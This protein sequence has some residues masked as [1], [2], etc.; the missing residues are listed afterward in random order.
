MPEDFRESAI[1]IYFETYRRHLH[2]MFADRPGRI[3]GDL[4][5]FVVADRLS[6]EQDALGQDEHVGIDSPASLR[7]QI[8]PPNHP[9]LQRSPHECPP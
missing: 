4:E 1:H 6:G 9:P 5:G 7:L 8:P 2:A 3:D